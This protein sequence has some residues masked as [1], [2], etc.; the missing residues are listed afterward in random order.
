MNTLEE[1]VK[2]IRTYIHD[3]NNHLTIIKGKSEMLVEDEAFK[4]NKHI[5]KILERTNQTVELMV[6]IRKAV[7]GLTEQD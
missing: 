6:E 3:I 1:K 2:Q 7:I 4:D 5:S